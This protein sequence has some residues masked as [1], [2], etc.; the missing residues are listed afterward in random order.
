MSLTPAGRGLVTSQQ[1]EVVAEFERPARKNMRYP[2]Q[3]RV[4]FWWKDERGEMRQGEGI[5]RDIS[6]SGA[7]VFASD[8]PPVGTE[9][10]LRIFLAPVPEVT[11]SLRVKVEGRV[12]RVDPITEGERGGGFAILS[13]DTMFYED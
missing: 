11:K 12:L 2:V 5:S 4:S 10:G 6:V 1:K 13:R 3:A 9:I 7:F 8:C